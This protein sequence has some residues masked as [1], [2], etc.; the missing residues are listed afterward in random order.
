MGQLFQ[1]NSSNIVWSMYLCSYK[2]PDLIQIAL[3]TLP[4]P[5]QFMSK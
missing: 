4:P 3:S 1:K 5:P 2:N